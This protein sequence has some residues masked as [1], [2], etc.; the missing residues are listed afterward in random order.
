M[1]LEDPMYSTKYRTS[2]YINRHRNRDFTVEL[3]YVGLTQAPPNKIPGINRLTRK[4]NPAFPRGSIGVMVSLFAPGLKRE[5]SS[6]NGLPPAGMYYTLR[7]DISKQ[8]ITESELD[9]CFGLV[10]VAT[11]DKHKTFSAHTQ[12]NQQSCSC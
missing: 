4:G 8:N 6:F 9:N 2:S 1:C 5:H 10:S 11:G 12:Y 3:A 7:T